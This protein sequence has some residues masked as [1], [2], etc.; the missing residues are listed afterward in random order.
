MSKTWLRAKERDKNYLFL[1]MAKQNSRRLHVCILKDSTIK[2]E[3][4]LFNNTYTATYQMLEIKMSSII[5][6]H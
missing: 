5:I 4:V 3:M 1:T 2:F 6:Y